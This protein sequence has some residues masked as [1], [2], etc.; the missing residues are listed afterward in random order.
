MTKKKVKNHK[1]SE[2]WKKYKLEGGLVEEQLIIAEE[3]EGR[4]EING[5]Y[6]KL[7]SVVPHKDLLQ[8]LETKN[9]DFSF[10]FQDSRFRGNVSFQNG[11]YM[12]V[13]RLLSQNIPDHH[14]LH[15]SRAVD[16]QSLSRNHADAAAPPPP[17]ART[18]LQV[19]L[20]N[21]LRGFAADKISASLRVRCFFPSI[22]AGRTAH[23]IILFKTRTHQP[24]KTDIR[25]V[26]ALK[27]KVKL[28]LPHGE[29]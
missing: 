10:Q 3:W 25:I 23:I 18:R 29:I 16:F 20:R 17:L 13:L 9:L 5:E 27:N 26:I 14:V 24:W 21:K 22:A 2:R 12:T 15:R 28:K 6:E 11:Y 4:K 19:G 1:T 7:Y 8:L